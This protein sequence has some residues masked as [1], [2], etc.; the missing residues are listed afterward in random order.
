MSYQKR[1]DSVLRLQQLSTKDGKDR[2][3]S[4]LSFICKVN[5]TISLFLCIPENG[6][7]K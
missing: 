7:E 4:N 6:G 5:S 1:M 2:L 3:D